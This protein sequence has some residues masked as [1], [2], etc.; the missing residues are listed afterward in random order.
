[1]QYI[2]LPLVGSCAR[3]EVMDEAP[4]GRLWADCESRSGWRVI[5]RGGR[6]VDFK[7]ISKQ[8]GSWVARMHTIANE[9]A[10]CS[11]AHAKV[12]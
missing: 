9:I 12:E 5:W 11:L 4:G 1:M 10:Q 6:W 7:M 8:D 3:R 2:I